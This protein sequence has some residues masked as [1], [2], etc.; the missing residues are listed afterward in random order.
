MKKVIFVAG[1]ILLS[2]LI[3]ALGFWGG[4]TYQRTQSEQ[5][6]QEFFSSRGINPEQAPGNLPF[7]FPADPT[8]GRNFGQGALGGGGGNRIVGQ[9][10]NVSGNVLTISTSQNT[11]TINLTEDT[12]IEKTIPAST[13]DLQP[14]VQVAVTGQRDSDEK[15]NASQVLINLV[16]TATAP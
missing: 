10:E 15:F 14:G 16:P 6:R 9:I 4:M 7:T 11:V 8:T 5:V 12:Q 1:G 13:S 2:I 3:G